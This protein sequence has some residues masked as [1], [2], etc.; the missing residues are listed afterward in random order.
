MAGKDARRF[1]ILPTRGF[2]ASKTT[3]NATQNTLSELQHAGVV[4]L[5]HAAVPAQNVKVL[6]SLHE[7]GP[8]LVEMTEVQA[9]NLRKNNP[10]LRI[11]PEVFYEIARARHIEVASG[12]TAFPTA[13]LTRLKL[14]VVM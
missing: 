4:R 14:T 8:K 3:G 13:N 11:V 10:G 7:N 12:K 2:V 9:F 1:I 5:R 6:S